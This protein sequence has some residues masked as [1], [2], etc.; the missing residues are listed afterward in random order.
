MQLITVESSMIHVVVCDKGKRIL[1]IVFNTGRTYQYGNVP[2]EVYDEFLKAE[3]K[4]R[5]FL[6]NIRDVYAYWQ[7]GRARR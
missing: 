5:Y 4:G 3:S 1:Q 7:I 2:P 6:A